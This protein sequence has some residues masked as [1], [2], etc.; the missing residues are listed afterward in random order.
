MI[1]ARVSAVREDFQSRFPRNGAGNLGFASRK[2]ATQRET[3]SFRG[4]LVAWPL[5]T[6]NLNTDT[7]TERVRRKEGGE[8]ALRQRDDLDHCCIKRNYPK[9]LEE[10]RLLADHRRNAIYRSTSRRNPRPINEVNIG[11]VALYA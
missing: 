1:L 10:K 2:A 9:A 4:R 5:Y 11:S 8:K 7:K 6:R 3:F